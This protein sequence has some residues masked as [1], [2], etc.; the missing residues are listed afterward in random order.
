MSEHR[1]WM[2]LWQLGIVPAEIRGPAADTIR[3]VG[4]ICY[5][6]Y[7]QATGWKPEHVLD[8]PGHCC[9][10]TGVFCS[11]LGFIGRPT[12]P[13]RYFS[14]VSFHYFL[15]TPDAVGEPD[16]L[17]VDPTWR[18]YLTTMSPDEKHKRPKALVCP[19][20]E[21]A[22]RLIDLGVPEQTGGELIVMHG[23]GHFNLEKGPEYKTLPKLLDI[24][25]E[26]TT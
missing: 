17:T 16:A 20:V 15:R 8:N 7:M 26:R 3:F 23:Q 25:L 24:I 2:P 13:M 18:Q 9:P 6:G 1:R 21:V 4:D 14:G 5:K 12:T 19:T 22:D 11:R 10:M